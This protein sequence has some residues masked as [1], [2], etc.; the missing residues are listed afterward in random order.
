MSTEGITETLQVFD[1]AGVCVCA[2]LRAERFSMI[3]VIE[4]PAELH[5]AGLGALESLEAQE[6]L[7]K[8]IRR[9]TQHGFELL[10]GQRRP[11]QILPGFSLISNF[12]DRWL[13]VDVA[14]KTV[15]V[16]QGP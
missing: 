1:K 14:N 6:Q 12:G 10:P 8:S 2:S 11:E 4:P 13:I 15:W 9:A 7:A 3:P 16:Q 5:A